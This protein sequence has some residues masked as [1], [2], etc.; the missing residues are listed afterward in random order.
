MKEIKEMKETPYFVFKEK[1]LKNNY[2]EFEE[3]CKKY[4]DE[5]VI[6][7]SVKTNSYE[8]L[9]YNLAGLGST[10]EISSM[11]EILKV[12]Q[13]KVFNGPNKT[14]AELIIAIEKGILI[15]IDNKSEIDKIIDLMK[16]KEVKVNLRVSFNEDKFGFEYDELGEIIDYCST[17]NLK[18]IGLSFHPGT[19]ANLKYYEN[20]I[21]KIDEVINSIDINLEYLDIG[22]GFPDSF[23]LRN[24]NAGLEDYFKL[25]SVLKKFNAKIILEPGRCLVSD[26]F[27]L[28]SKVNVIKNKDG[29][30]YAFLDVGINIL[31]KISLSNYNF[32]K[33]EDGKKNEVK[34]YILAGPLLFGNDIIGKFRGSLKE[35]DLIRIK[36]V[37]AYCYNLGWEISY[38]KPEIIVE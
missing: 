31:S 21:K 23:Q 9:I 1:I 25:I 26:A 37:G 8:N 5:Y 10:F 18:V 2:K 11:E 30:N 33:M 32:S 38:K 17:N 20:F 7:Y 28:I 4:L 16:G 35:G 6:A 15:N 3:L 36:N 14:E 13:A 34:E 24:L 22:G 12:T 29:K 27:E 19:Q